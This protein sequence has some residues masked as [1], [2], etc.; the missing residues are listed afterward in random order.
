MG[1]REPEIREHRFEDDGRIPNNSQL[2]LLV[3]LN[4]LGESETNPAR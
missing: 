2:P 4:V 3:Y 1:K